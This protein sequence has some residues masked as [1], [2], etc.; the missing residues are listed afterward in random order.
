MRGGE[1]GEAAHEGEKHIPAPKAVVLYEGEGKR[2]CA[3][4]WRGNRGEGEVRMRDVE[5]TGVEGPEGVGGGVVDVE[6]P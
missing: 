4:R 3:S 1:R 2:D 6:V 5:L